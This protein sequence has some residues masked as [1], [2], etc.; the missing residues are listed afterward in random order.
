MKQTTM[1]ISGMTCAACATR[2]EK[3]LSKIEGVTEA[4]V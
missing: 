3:G 4:N 1:Q 2:I